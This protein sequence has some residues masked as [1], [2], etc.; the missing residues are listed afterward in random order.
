MKQMIRYFVALMILG[1]ALSAVT[2]IANAQTPKQT[3]PE[4]VIEN[5]TGECIDGVYENLKAT[6]IDYNSYKDIDD[7]IDTTIWDLVDDL[8]R[9]PIPIRPINMNFST[10]RDLPLQAE[11]EVSRANVLF[12]F[13][14]VS[15]DSKRFFA[16]FPKIPTECVTTETQLEAGKVSLLQK[17]DMFD[18]NNKRYGLDKFNTHIE[19]K[20]G[21]CPGNKTF[22]SYRVALTT[23]KPHVEKM[24]DAV[25]DQYILLKLVD[26]SFVD[27]LFDERKF[28]EQYFND[29]YEAIVNASN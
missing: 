7:A 28:Y 8:P 5:G 26:R 4:I 25:R 3:S 27:R 1:M 22:L 13:Q 29:L 14:P 23:I 20:K 15:L 10:P 11:N 2:S 16:I 12:V 9:M 6:L 24:K 19:L 18:P 21:I 17:C